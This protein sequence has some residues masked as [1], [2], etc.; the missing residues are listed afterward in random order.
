MQEVV[1][2]SVP[3]ILSGFYRYGDTRHIFSDTGS[4]ESI[5]WKPDL[6]IRESIESYWD[7]L[8][9]QDEIDDILDYAGRHMKNL[10]VI[11]EV[12]HSG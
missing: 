4:L 7:Y 2:R 12:K 1:G 9:R 10:Q 5:G 3:P 6:G 8:N 11:R